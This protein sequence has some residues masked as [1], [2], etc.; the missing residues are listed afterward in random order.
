[1]LRPAGEGLKVGR[2]KG[3][4]SEVSLT[5]TKSAAILAMS[6][7]HRR[8]QLRW[9]GDGY[10]SEALRPRCRIAHTELL[11]ELCRMLG[12]H[13]G[14]SYREGSELFHFTVRTPTRLASRARLARTP[15]WEFEDYRP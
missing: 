3:S 7:P 5:R 11:R 6:R 12:L 1:M 4:A 14:P 10:G 8:A 13:T 2:I 9:T 15:S